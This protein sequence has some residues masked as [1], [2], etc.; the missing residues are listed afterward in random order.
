MAEDDPFV[1]P[2]PTRRVLPD[3]PLPPPTPNQNQRDS[4]YF[5]HVSLGQQIQEKG[6][7]RNKSSPEAVNHG[8]VVE[9]PPPMRRL[10]TSDEVRR[11]VRRSSQVHELSAPPPS[12]PFPVRRFDST[13]LFPVAQSVSSHSPSKA[14]SRQS[15]EKRRS[16]KS[17]ELEPRGFTNGGQ[18][19]S[20]VKRNRSQ[21]ASH[22][23]NRGPSEPEAS[24]DLVVKQSRLLQYLE[25]VVPVRD[26]AQLLWTKQ[27]LERGEL[28]ED[29]HRSSPL[30]VVNGSSNYSEGTPPIV[31]PMNEYTLTRKD[32][33][34]LE[35]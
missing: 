2:L 30:K 9:H 20:A 13:A 15:S 34:E 16:R 18:Q 21:S 12:M 23:R 8:W 10:P 7:S 14:P 27:Q 26:P 35:L 22:S 4:G 6:H 33:A 25:G 28:T 24:S 1:V 17:T 3:V 29:E 32:L 5:D 11:L 31:D 19:S